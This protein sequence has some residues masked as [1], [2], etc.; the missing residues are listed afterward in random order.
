MRIDFT[1]VLDRLKS[2]GADSVYQIDLPD[3]MKYFTFNRMFLVRL[4]GG[5]FISTFPNIGPERVNLHGIDNLCFPN[6]DL[7]PHAPVIPGAPGLFFECEPIGRGRFE[8][9]VFTPWKGNHTW[10]YMGDYE[11]I[12]VTSLSGDEYSMQSETVSETVSINMAGETDW[13]TAL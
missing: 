4:Y 5:S 13:S 10:G 11:F 8:C 6:L 3:E 1:T 7:N 2:V 9:R 12:P